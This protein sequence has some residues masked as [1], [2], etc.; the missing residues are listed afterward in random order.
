MKHT[1]EQVKTMV[2]QNV[3]GAVVQVVP[4]AN[5]TLPSSLL[6]DPK[7]AVRV[8]EY[9]RDAAEFQFD[10]ASNATGVDWPS[11]DVK[12]KVKKLVEGVEKDVEEITKTAAYLEVVYHLYSTAL[13]Q[14]PLAIRMRTTDRAENNKLPSLTPVWRSCEFQEREIYDLYGVVFEGHP[15]L[16]RILMWDEYKHFPMRKDFVPPAEEDELEVSA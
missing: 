8:A 4:N 5:P 2:E 13:V 14:G 11:R 15:D 12:T 10:L 16:R 6:I 9:L 3:P 1:L 7:S